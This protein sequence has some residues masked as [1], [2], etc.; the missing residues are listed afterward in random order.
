VRT[1]WYPRRRTR[2][3]LAKVEPAARQLRRRHGHVVGSAVVAARGEGQLRRPHGAAAWV[4]C[5]RARD[6]PVHG[7]P[8][9]TSGRPRRGLRRMS[10]GDGEGAPSAGSAPACS[11]GCR[12]TLRGRLRCRRAPGPACSGSTVRADASGAVSLLPPR[13]TSDVSS[14]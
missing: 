2:R 6:G 12:G 11:P 10:S 4:P 5:M 14:S 1:R 8:V 9:G 7:G 13:T 3:S